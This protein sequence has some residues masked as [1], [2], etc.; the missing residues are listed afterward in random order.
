MASRIAGS[1]LVIITTS[2]A[3]IFSLTQAPVDIAFKFLV[4]AIKRYHTKAS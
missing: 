4:S 2:L 1:W 3:V